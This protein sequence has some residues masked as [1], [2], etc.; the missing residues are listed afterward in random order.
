MGRETQHLKIH[1]AGPAGPVDAIL[2][3]GA[4]RSCELVGARAVDIVGVLESN[5]W[6]GS[7]RVQMRLSD[8]RRAE[9]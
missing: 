7:E 1:T 3:G 6:N 8:F 2:W 5:V 4:G 9:G